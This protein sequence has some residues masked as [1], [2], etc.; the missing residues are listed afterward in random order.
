MKRAGTACV[1]L[2]YTCKYCQPVNADTKR[3]SKMPQQTIIKPCFIQIS[4]ISF[5]INIAVVRTH[6]FITF[7]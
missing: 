2:I 5:E 1:R 4:R 7:W 3:T 6:V